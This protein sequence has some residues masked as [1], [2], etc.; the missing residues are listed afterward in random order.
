MRIYLDYAAT[1]PLDQRV[2]DA[3]RDFELKYFGNP[4]SQHREGQQAR[5]EIDFARAKVAKFLFC[6][7]QEII[8]TSG[9]TEANNLAIQGVIN[10]HIKNY[11][12][13]PHVITTKLEHQS[14]YNTIQELQSRGVIEATFVS[15]SSNGLIQADDIIGAIK[16][17]TVLVSCIFVS[18]EVGSILPVREIGQALLRLQP[19][20]Y[21]L[22]PIFHVD[23]VQAAKFYNCNV[24]KLNC[25]L[26]TL[27][28]HKLY[29]PKG[30]GALFVKK[31][32][33]IANL[34]LG[35]SQEYGLRP[36]TQNTS[37]II[38]MAKA[39]ELLGSLD[40]RSEAAQNITKLRDQLISSVKNGIL[41]GPTGEARTCDNTSF[42]FFGLDQDTLI[43]ALDLEGI[44]AST[45][46]ACVSGSSKPSHVLEALGRTTGQTA[47]TARL[48][49]GKLTTMAEIL[50][51][52]KTLNNIVN[53]LE[54]EK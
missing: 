30:I 36:G 54:H 29:G 17:N 28:A 47:A 15:P 37:G 11:K 13:K 23:A 43:T 9:A 21:N 39:I 25:D 22:K 32:L 1:T 44:A 10:S 48:S 41:N 46:S 8:F 3:M 50:R 42:T 12:I 53:R 20:T 2:A 4:S 7:P 33:K 14:V 19:T 40:D 6:K 45:G 34:T 16:D 24:E 49:L 52:V 18:N 26:L 51:A 38:G 35:G 5:A 27:S 31:G